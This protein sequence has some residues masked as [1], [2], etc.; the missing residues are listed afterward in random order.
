MIKD[1]SI[2]A[3]IPARGGSKGLPGKNILSFAGQPLI[4]WT[5]QAAQKSKY[6]DK[7][8][9]STDNSTISDVAK[10][11]NGDVPFIRP[12]NLACDKTPSIDVI[13]HAID[14]FTQRGTNFDYFLLLEPTS[15][16]R[17]END[18][19][20]AISKLVSK[21]DI[22]DS[23]IGV[24]KIEATHPVFDVKINS[25]GLI[26]SYTS[27]DFES[28]RRQDIEPLYFFEGSIYLSD[29]MTLLK[30]KNF[31]HERTL[32]YIIPRWKSLEIDELPDLIMAEAIM[33][34]LEQLEKYSA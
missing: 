20:S 8:I 7:C 33:N 25:L 4:S 34:N 11:Y 23:I 29:T 31:C 1:K 10:K 27:T 18:I 32:P 3:V 12:K 5:I 6:I 13:F 26:E 24:S 21:R 17:N 30:R 2:L 22:A 28:F 9:V 16:L 15:P 19:D 14:F